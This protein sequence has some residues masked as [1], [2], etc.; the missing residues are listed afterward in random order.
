MTTP[1]VLTNR[2]PYTSEFD[3][4]TNHENEHIV[5]KAISNFVRVYSPSTSINVESMDTPAFTISAAVGPSIPLHNLHP[6]GK[7]NHS[8]CGN[9][10][11][12]LPLLICVSSVGGYRSSTQYSGVL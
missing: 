10:P 9:R 5:P 2:D 1:Y 6:S 7:Q 11:T 8:I 4:N 3:D 12:F